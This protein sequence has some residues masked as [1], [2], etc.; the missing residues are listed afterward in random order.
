MLEGNS[1]PP[2]LW[3]DPYRF[4]PMWWNALFVHLN[5]H[6]QIEKHALSLAIYMHWA[7]TN[8][9]QIMMGIIKNI[10]DKFLGHICALSSLE[11]S[12]Q[13]I[14]VQ[15]NDWCSDWHSWVQPVRLKLLT[16]S[17]NGCMH[18]TSAPSNLKIDL[19]RT[20]HHWNQSGRGF[21]RG[22]GMSHHFLRMLWKT[23]QKS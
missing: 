16:C 1:K 4:T 17:P 10:K 21:T 23:A 15:S 20:S 14:V 6:E 13:L 2:D 3:N 5:S 7:W 18:Y 19:G 11:L 9:L 12:H 22:L 8:M